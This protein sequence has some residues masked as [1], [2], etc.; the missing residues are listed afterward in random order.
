[1]KIYK[2]LLSFSLLL[3]LSYYSQIGIGTTT[4]MQTVHIDAMQNN[5]GTA[6]NKNEDDVVMTSDGKL[7][8]GNINPITKLDMRNSADNNV[9]GVG[10]TTQSASVAKGGAIQY[11]NGLKYS[12]GTNWIS[13]PGRSVNALVHANKGTTQN[14]SYNSYNNVSSW[15]EQTDYTSSFDPALG[16]FSAPK[17]GVYTASFNVALTSSAIVNNTWL[18]VVLKSNTTNGIP[19]Y[20]CMYSYPGYSIGS[21]TNIVSGNCTGIFYLNQGETITPQV[22]QNL[23]NS[24][25]SGTRTILADANYN[26]LTISGQ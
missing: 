25:T 10:K 22:F 9:I 5:S 6:V 12:D 19:E 3:P 18:E 2:K 23:Q 26:T 15:S 13:L 20:R 24:A 11:D 16:V 8:V 7:G 14:I 21:T 1:M 17:A 4:P